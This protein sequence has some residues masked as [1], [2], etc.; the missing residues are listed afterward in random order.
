[1]KIQRRKPSIIASS[2]IK[3]KDKFLL[4]YSPIFKVWRVPGGRVEFGEKLK[5]TLSREI[6]EELKINITEPIFLGYGEDN[7]YN[8]NLKHDTSRLVMYF[9]VNTKKPISLDK[10]EFSKYKW[11]TWSELKKHKNKE[12]SLRDFFSKNPNINL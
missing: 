11:L 6:K 1:M 8:Y 10:N 9:L 5:E 2:F 4:A 3:Y 7:Q 12:D